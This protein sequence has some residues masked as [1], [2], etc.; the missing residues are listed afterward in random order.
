MEDRQLAFTDNLP[1]LMHCAKLFNSLFF[2]L[3]QEVEFCLMSHFIDK[4]TD[5]D[6]VACP[7]SHT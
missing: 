6:Y 3:S 4:K 7:E 1:D 2:L 5:I